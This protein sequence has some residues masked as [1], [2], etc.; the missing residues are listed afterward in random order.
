MTGLLERFEP[1]IYSSTMVENGKPSPD[2]FL[3]AADAMGVEPGNCAVVEDSPAGIE[4]AHRAGMRVYAY[5]GATHAEPGDLRA[6]A[7][8]MSPD[9]IFED[10]KDLP[11]LLAAAGAVAKDG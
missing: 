10:M 7:E 9:A 4:A 11:H 2:L 8:A 5:V 3:Y 6:S 1:H